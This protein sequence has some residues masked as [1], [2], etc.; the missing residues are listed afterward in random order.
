MDERTLSERT[1]KRLTEQGLTL[2]TAESCTGGLV[3]KLITD[4]PGASRYYMGGVVS[5]SNEAKVRLL[6]VRRRTLQSR[7]AVSAETAGEM[8]EGAVKALGADIGIATTGIA[9]P[10]GGTEAKPV[11]LV[12]VAL[13]R[14]DGDTTTRRLIL[15]GGR[16]EIRRTA[17]LKALELILENT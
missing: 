7:G 6:G 9:G 8:A 13:A 5:Y 16:E 4:L 11:G 17:A 3:S 2:A 1:K 14:R 12:Y 10:E 15:G